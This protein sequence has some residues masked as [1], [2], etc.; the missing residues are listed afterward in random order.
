MGR[1]KHAAAMEP[2]GLE[3]RT[4]ILA[5]TGNDA[6]LTSNFLAQAELSPHVCFDVPRLCEEIRKGCGAVILAEEVIGDSSISE[7]IKTLDAQPSWSDLPIILIS[8]GG[9]KSRVH[10]RR[11]G[12]FGPGGNVL[13]LERPFRPD[14]LVRTVEAA[15]RSRQRQYEGRDR[16]E[17]LKR[18]YD[19]IQRVSRAKD[20]FLAALSHELRTPLN[21]VLL[22]SSEAANDRE[23][24]P[25]V[26][27]NFDMIRRNVE[28]EAR[29]IDDLLDLTRVAAGKLKFEKQHVNVHAILKSAIALVQ[30]EMD[31]KRIT[32]AQNL[33]AF[34]TI[35]SGDG[36]RLQQIF[37]NVLKNAVKFTPLEGTITVETTSTGKEF[38]VSISDTGL[39]MT[40]DELRRAFE[41]FA[42]GEHAKDSHRFG[43]LGLGLAICKKIG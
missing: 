14:T 25:G 21:P 11:L 4:L 16:M 19:E 15:L 37:S 10:L 31:Q 42:Q 40:A 32:L 23:L 26:R 18:A 22:V 7:L 2:M 30:S 28:L 27:A 38:S 39:G 36:M 41:I 5:P 24:S 29:M 8:S 9:E 17:E 3:Q 1:A 33:A 20:D 12:I 34:Q 13:V 35:I 6:R 43:G